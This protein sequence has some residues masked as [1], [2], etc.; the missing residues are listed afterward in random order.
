MCFADARARVCVGGWMGGAWPVCCA[1]AWQTCQFIG[2]L[3]V[4][5]CVFGMGDGIG[6]TETQV[7]T[8]ASEAE[9]VTLVMTSQPDANGATYQVDGEACYAEFGMTG[10]N[11]NEGWQSCSFVAGF[12]DYVIGDGVGGSEQ[13]IGQAASRAECVNMVLAERPFANGACEDQR[14]STDRSVSFGG[15][16]C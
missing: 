7:G 11:G 14:C 9:C 15:L 12:C 1:A 2:E 10:K 4:T 13:M 5:G 6:G 3:D 8:A 16:D